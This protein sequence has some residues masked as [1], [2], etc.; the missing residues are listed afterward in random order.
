MKTLQI[1]SAYENTIVA[2]GTQ[3][4]TSVMTSPE[5]SHEIKYLRIYT[6]VLFL[7]FSTL[8]FLLLLFEIYSG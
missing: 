1:E 8:F 6:L 5:M 4:C 2:T 3:L 7:Y